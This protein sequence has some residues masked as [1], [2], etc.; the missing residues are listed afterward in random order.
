VNEEEQVNPQTTQRVV[1][2]ITW[3]KEPHGL[4]PKKL[5]DPKWIQEGKNFKV[6]KI[7]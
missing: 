2:I 3:K 1:Y 6:F 5:I 7:G 4:P